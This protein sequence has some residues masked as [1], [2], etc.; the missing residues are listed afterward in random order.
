MVEPG[1]RNLISDVDGIL[2]G[3]ASDETVR[4]G[5]TVIMNDGRMNAAVDVRGGGPGTRETDAL[6][7]ACAVDGIDAL[8]FA[9]G[10][11]FGLDAASGVMSWMAGQERGFPV[12]P[13]RIPIVPSAIIFDLANGGDKSWGGSA[14]YRGLGKLAAASVDAEFDLGNAG[15]G[16]G[17]MAGRIKGGLGSTSLVSEDG[18]VVGALVVANPVGSV[19][20]PGTSTFWAWALEQNAELGGQKAPAGDVEIDL[21]LPLES[22]I[23]GDVQ[24]G[25]NTTVAAVA[26][27][28]ELDRA[29]LQRVAIMAQDGFARAIRPVH[30]PF[31]GDT[32]FALSTRARP[33]E[34]LAALAVARAG[35]MAADCVARAVARAV[36]CAD[37]VWGIPSYRS[38]H[39]GIMS[40]EHREV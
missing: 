26:T 33:V 29:Q 23:G 24:A 2:V 7:P 3:N 22:R 11:A 12:G 38:V 25:A 36:Y 14:P 6:N 21:E 28:L 1:P 39:A 13:F 30:T 18:I 17:A 37:S 34:G 35:M 31:D 40:G 20:M 27:N 9:G 32:V 10:S 16:L 4:T 5:V 19:V 15:A 8:V